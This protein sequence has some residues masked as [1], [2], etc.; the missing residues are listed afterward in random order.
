MFKENN[1]YTH[2]QTNKP[3]IFQAQIVNW[4]YKIVLTSL[5]WKNK[6][7][8]YI[9]LLRNLETE[10]RWVYQFYCF[11]GKIFA[12]A[13]THTHTKKSKEKEKETAV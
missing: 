12:N 10:L 9:Y 5:K 8:I 1:K 13:D 6:R 11:K 2:K 4:M 7:L 3:N